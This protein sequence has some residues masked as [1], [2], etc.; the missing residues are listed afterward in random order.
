MFNKVITGKNIPGLIR[1]IKSFVAD[2]NTCYYLRQDGT[3]ILLSHHIALDRPPNLLPWPL[4]YIQKRLAYSIKLNVIP[5][6]SSKNVEQETVFEWKNFKKAIM[7]FLI[8]VDDPS[9]IQFLD[10]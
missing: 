9:L 6:K 1:R 8:H 7:Q 3:A 5:P 4:I 2:G 10:H